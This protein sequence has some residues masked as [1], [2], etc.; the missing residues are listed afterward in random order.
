MQTI[1]VVFGVA[2]LVLVV[3]IIAVIIVVVVVFVLVVVVVSFVVIVCKTAE[4]ST[5]KTLKLER[6]RSRALKPK[7]YSRN[8]NLTVVIVG[9]ETGLISRINSKIWY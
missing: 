6:Q 7:I 2:A 8:S 9:R 3:G 4:N 5:D 1:A